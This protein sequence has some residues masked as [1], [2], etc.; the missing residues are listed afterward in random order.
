MKNSRKFLRNNYLDIFS[1]IGSFIFSYTIKKSF[2]STLIIFIAISIA[3]VFMAKPADA[4]PADKPDFASSI[5]CRDF[6][7]RKLNQ[8]Y[9]Y[10]RKKNPEL[11][12][13][14]KDMKLN[15]TPV[16]RMDYANKPNE[17]PINKI[18]NVAAP[19]RYVATP[20]SI[21]SYKSS[22]YRPSHPD[23][24][25]GKT[26]WDKFQKEEIKVSSA[27]VNKNHPDFSNTAECNSFS[28]NVMAH[29]NKTIVPAKA[30]Y[31]KDQK[32]NVNSKQ[33]EV[34]DISSS[35]LKNNPIAIQGIKRFS[36]DVSTGNDMSVVD[37]IGIDYSKLTQANLET[38]QGKKYLDSLSTKYKWFNVGSSADGLGCT[39]SFTSNESN[40]G[41]DYS[42]L[43]DSEQGA[44]YAISIDKTFKAMVE[45]IAKYPSS[46]ITDNYRK[47][48]KAA[49]D[50]IN[51][52]N[53]KFNNYF[54]V[55]GQNSAIKEF[56]KS[57]ENLVYSLEW[58]D[59]MDIDKFNSGLVILS[60][61]MGGEMAVNDS[62][63]E[64]YNIT[65]WRLKTITRD[66]GV[67]QFMD[68]S[69]FFGNDMLK[70][71]ANNLDNFDSFLVMMRDHGFDDFKKEIVGFFGKESV[72]NALLMGGDSLYSLFG[73]ILKNPYYFKNNITKIFNQNDI[74]HKFQADPDGLGRLFLSIS[75][76]RFAYEKIAK[77]Y[78]EKAIKEMFNTNIDSLDNM[79]F[80]AHYIQLYKFENGFARLSDII[81]KESANKAY[82]ENTRVIA[83]ELEKIHDLSLSA[84]QIESDFSDIEF[85][86]S[87]IKELV[88]VLHLDKGAVTDIFTGSFDVLNNESLF[89]KPT[90]E[91]ERR[92]N[93]GIAKKIGVENIIKYT[94]ELIDIF[95]I[96]EIQSLP[97]V[98]G[99]RNSYFYKTLD[100]MHEMGGL[101]KIIDELAVSYERTKIV[102][103]LSEMRSRSIARLCPDDLKEAIKNRIEDKK[104][105][106]PLA[107][108]IYPEYDY[109]GAFIVNG[110]SV[111]RSI[112]ANNYKIVYYEVSNLTQLANAVRDATKN[113]VAWAVKLSGHGTK[114]SIRFGED[115]SESYFSLNNYK[116][117]LDSGL[118]LRLINGGVVILE[119]CSTGKD[120]REVIN[121]RLESTN[122][123]NMLANALPQASGVFGPVEDAQTG[124]I[125]YNNSLIAGIE[126]YKEDYKTGIRRYVESYNG[127]S[128]RYNVGNNNIWNI[129]K[130]FNM[131]V[132]DLIKYNYNSN[133]NLVG[134]IVIPRAKFEP[135]VDN[136]QK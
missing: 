45:D 9:E 70:K 101:N 99:M 16:Y 26:A 132:W 19:E 41:I 8:F 49:S 51:A 48:A 5:A 105:N 109:N 122:M 129:A 22:M 68:I 120:K 27:Y 20:T 91:D 43:T 94:N 12:L 126:C 80:Y 36:S 79:I 128:L 3:S 130:Q 95:G 59:E 39:L 15:I 124:S 53:E 52:N 33:I 114:D 81:G 65:I 1:S 69:E 30:K 86:A 40:L 75:I 23:Y 117:L 14:P 62:F 47:Y 98:D 84:E 37:S 18:Y 67:K 54:S 92:S 31:R 74:I 93:V 87:L 100:N 24:G 85:V 10:Q 6:H 21:S 7:T 96:D 72:E 44:I 32:A 103:V 125:L 55:L 60:E 110:P 38:D 131:P 88:G 25:A 90:K 76:D 133:P 102:S 63:K 29:Y 118:T 58:L 34:A 121:Y 119:S 108:L 46:Q 73:V 134:Q 106:R 42:K 104:D 28:N 11:M 107:L 61:L 116:D 35:V 113:E 127:A 136:P 111:N 89:F 13:A 2:Y 82:L 56:V 83:W 71:A 123:V 135:L 66:I 57:P 17:V 50:I 77:L 112:S 78:G 4:D 64:D 97:F 115:N